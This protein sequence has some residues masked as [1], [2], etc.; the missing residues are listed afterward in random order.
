MDPM[1]PVSHRH[2][3]TLFQRPDQI[4]HPL[5]VV[6]PIINSV[7]FRSRWRLWEDFQKM[8]AESGAILYTAEVAFGERA[9]AI[10][11]ADNPRHI[12]LRTSSEF[13]MKESVINVA[14]QRLPADAK[15][16]AWV[17]ADTRFVRDDWANE[18]LHRLQHYAVVQMWSQY[19]NLTHTQELLGSTAS[20]FIDQYLRGVQPPTKCEYGY[21]R[22]GYPGAPGLAWAMRRDAWDLVGGLLDCC[23]LGAA[24]W[25]QAHGLVGRLTMGMI[26]KFH[27]RYQ[28]KLM[29]W[30]ER[31]QQLHRNVG[32]VPG[33]ALHYFHGPKSNRKYGSREQILIDCEYNPDTDLVRDWQGLYQLRVHDE[34]TRQLRDRLRE[35]MGQRNEDAL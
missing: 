17:D 34:R 30:Q 6:T 24:D 29:A 9:H 10:T 25:Y 31:A 4:A 35:Y 33:L 8:V 1:D 27:P 11:T 28:E 15:Y 26:G 12:Q 22:R 20:G 13:F 23:I 3:S 5:Y 32:V 16:I 19:Q 18:T 21:D 14:V 7:R 2:R